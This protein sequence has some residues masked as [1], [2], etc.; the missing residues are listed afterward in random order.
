MARRD[1]VDELQSAPG[2]GLRAVVTSSRQLRAAVVDADV[3]TGRR[4]D[5]NDL[6]RGAGVQDRVG[7]QL[8]HQQRCGVLELGPPGFGK[9]LVTTTR[10]CR[11]LSGTGSSWTR[12]STTP[13]R[14]RDVIV[15]PSTGAGPALPSTLKIIA[16][17]AR[18][19]FGAT[20]GRM[21][22]PDT[23]V[24]MDEHDQHRPRRP[25]LLG[26]AAI[27]SLGGAPDPA[28]LAEAAHATAQ[29]PGRRG[30]RRV[31]PGHH[32]AAGPAGRRSRT[33]HHRGAVVGAAGAV[34]ARR[35][36]A[37]LRAA[38]VGALRP[39]RGERRLLRGAARG[40][41]VERDRRR[42]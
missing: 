26:K 30:P 41:G 6:D 3:D 7:D 12:R 42:R 13:S 28:E 14:E 25:A 5:D 18:H 20:L 11:A 27:E 40:A 4:R 24:G 34:P 32:R 17:P 36:V 21:A 31:R 16:R 39:A 33:R 37:A 1:E 15:P 2:R 35:A 22:G 19:E 10:A 9:R 8:A 29:T 38:R 23:I